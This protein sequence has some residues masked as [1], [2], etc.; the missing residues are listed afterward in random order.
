MASH[1]EAAK[2]QTPAHPQTPLGMLGLEK[3]QDYM[4]STRLPGDEPLDAED[5]PLEPP[6]DPQAGIP[7]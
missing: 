2:R 1:V 3:A 6:S 5:A 4:L 7:F